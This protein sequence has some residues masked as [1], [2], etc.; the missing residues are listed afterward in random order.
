LT[1]EGES[2]WQDMLADESPSPEEIV[3]GMKDSQSRSKWLHDALSALPEREQ[4]IIRQ[5]HLNYDTVTLEELG[6]SL[7]ISK[8]RV[9]QLEQRAME[10]M[11]ASLVNHTDDAGALFAE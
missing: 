8:E 1:D 5:R 4:T 11:K 6:K 10:R 2:S 3:L 9:R 7:G